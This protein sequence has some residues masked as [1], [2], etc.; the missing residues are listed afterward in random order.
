MWETETNYV[1]SEDWNDGRS[2]NEIKQRMSP[3]VI[4]NKEIDVEV[5]KKFKAAQINFS[6]VASKD[7]ITNLI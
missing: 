4:E 1:A 5:K 7:I 2:T 3:T 6:K